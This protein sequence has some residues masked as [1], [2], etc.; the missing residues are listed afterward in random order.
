MKNESIY[1]IILEK[2]LPKLKWTTIDR[3]LVKEE[4]DLINTI[5]DVVE[6][7]VCQ[8]DTLKVFNYYI[9][10]GNGRQMLEIYNNYK[11]G[12]SSISFHGKL[13]RLN[14]YIWF[15]SYFKFLRF[16][17]IA[18]KLNSLDNEDFYELL[19]NNY[20]FRSSDDIVKLTNRLNI[21]LLTMV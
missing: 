2:C 16:G 6:L 17:N 13:K 8:Y 3:D 7:L 19:L 5:Y 21:F 12:S 1:S 10:V 15:T 18:H 11:W 20:R 9:P 4:Q 14:F